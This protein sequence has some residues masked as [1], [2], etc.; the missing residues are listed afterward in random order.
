MKNVKD[1]L[2]HKIGLKMR[3][4]RRAEKLTLRE[5][6][7]WLEVSPQQ[8]Q[9]YEVNATEIPFS[10]LYLFLQIFNISPER[11]FEVENDPKEI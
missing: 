11:F 6:G 2:N 1:N 8:V 7:E 10:K 4:I 9:K 5:I 3:Q